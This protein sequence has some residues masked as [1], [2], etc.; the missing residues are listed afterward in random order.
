MI[1]YSSRRHVVPTVVVVVPIVVVVPTV[2]VVPIVVVVVPTVVV[3]VPIVVVVVPT[4]VVVV[5]TAE[6]PR[7]SL[8]LVCYNVGFQTCV[9]PVC[10]DWHLRWAVAVC[11]RG[12]SI[13]FGL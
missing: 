2:V 8:V 12:I 6:V 1:Y 13:T 11:D 4:V 5:P 9:V 3:V 10:A 7:D